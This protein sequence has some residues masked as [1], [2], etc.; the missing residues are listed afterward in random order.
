MILF[1][2]RGKPHT[3][4]LMPFLMLF[5]QYVVAIG[6]SSVYEKVWTLMLFLEALLCLSLYNLFN[7]NRGP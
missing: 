4:A 3:Q 2:L 6:L 5:V 1:N 7:H